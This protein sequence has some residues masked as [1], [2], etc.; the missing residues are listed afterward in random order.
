[1][2]STGRGRVI[3]ADRE[4]IR[5]LSRECHD[6]IEEAVTLILE[7]GSP[8]LGVVAPSVARARNRA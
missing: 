8:R 4:G 5:R 3:V 2:I 1:V 6:A 7:G